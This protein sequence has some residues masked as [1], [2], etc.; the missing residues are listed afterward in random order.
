MKKQ[1]LYVRLQQLEAVSLRELNEL[2]YVSRS[3]KE[4]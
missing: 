4:Q 2:N 3:R 1:K